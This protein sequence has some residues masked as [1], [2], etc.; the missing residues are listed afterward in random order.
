MARPAASIVLELDPGADPIAG[1]VRA[2]DQAPR[3]FTGW[4]GLFAALRA[5]TGEGAGAARDGRMGDPGSN[6]Q[7]EL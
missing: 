3:A 4:T 1:Q 5:A 6:H 2:P 7:E